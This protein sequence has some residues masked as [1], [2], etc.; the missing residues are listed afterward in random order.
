MLDKAD[1]RRRLDAELREAELDVQGR[2]HLDTSQYAALSLADIGAGIH[3]AG[4][5]V[6]SSLPSSTGRML[7]L[8]HPETTTLSV[9]D[10]P[11]VPRVGLSSSELNWARERHRVWAKK[12][13]RQ[14]GLAFFHAVF[15]LIIL[16]S[17]LRSF[18]PAD[19]SRYFATLGVGIT[20]LLLFVLAVFKAVGARRKRWQEIGHL[21]ER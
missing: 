8:A 15:G 19:G 12:F 13:N 20:L 5:T 11:F 4:F 2:Y 17:A 9:S 7:V 18:G 21:V 6:V 1:S 10:G 16:V 14:I 3:A